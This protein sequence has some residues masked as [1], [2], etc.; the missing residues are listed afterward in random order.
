MTEFADTTSSS[1]T[2]C[3]GSGARGG[4]IGAR[5]STG[6]AAVPLSAVAV[7]ELGE[8]LV[9]DCGG[10]FVGHVRSSVGGFW[11]AAVLPGLVGVGGVRAASARREA[12]TGVVDVVDCGVDTSALPRGE[13]AAALG[14]VSPMTASVS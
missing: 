8:E 11:R 2:F 14:A 9:G 6:G 3:G 12:P 5:S 1:N 13:E 10:V 4:S 7:R